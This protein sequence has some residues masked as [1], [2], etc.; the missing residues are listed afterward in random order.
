MTHLQEKHDQIPQNFQNKIDR[1][2]RF[3]RWTHPKTRT[4]SFSEKLFSLF[5]PFP[6]L[7][8]FA[9]RGSCEGRHSNQSIGRFSK[10]PTPGAP[11]GGPA[12]PPQPGPVPRR[13]PRPG[14]VRRTGSLRPPGTPFI[15]SFTPLVAGRFFFVELEVHVFAPPA[16]R[17]LESADSAILSQLR[18]TPCA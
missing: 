7:C 6:F 13:V 3:H 11:P 15:H 14:N 5:S 8:P 9:N 2:R 10:V 12:P 18:R 4:S 17:S 1:N 16:S